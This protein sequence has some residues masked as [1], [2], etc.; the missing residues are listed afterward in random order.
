MLFTEEALVALVKQLQ[1]DEPDD[2]WT[3]TQSTANP[4]KIAVWDE[5]KIFLGYLGEFNA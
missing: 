3:Y 1:K 4:R 2:G 5:N